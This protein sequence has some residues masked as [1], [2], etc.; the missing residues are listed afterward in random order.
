MRLTSDV[1]ACIRLT[2]TLLL[3]VPSTP[4]WCCRST[5]GYKLTNDRSLQFGSE[6]EPFYSAL[7]S[8]CLIL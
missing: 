6:L 4:L 7:F 2:F 1:G 8:F 5:E 3:Q